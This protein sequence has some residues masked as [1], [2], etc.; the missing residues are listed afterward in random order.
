MSTFRTR[1][2]SFFREQ[3]V[4]T[5]DSKLNG[6]LEVSMSSGRYVLNSESSNYSFGSLHRVFRNALNAEGPKIIELGQVLVLGLGAGSVPHIMHKE[7][8]YDV[9]ITGVE[10][11]KKVLE[12]G[13]KYFGLMK[14]PL[15]EVVHADAHDYVSNCSKLFGLVV[16]DLYVGRDV[17]PECEEEL[18]WAK[19]G[20]IV[21]KP[22]LL[23]FNK[24]VYDEETRAQASR[25]QGLAERYFDSMRVRRIIDTWENHIIIGENQKA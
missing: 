5:Y 1:F 18:F 22:G 13:E 19:L 23:M 6:K 9:K 24:V 20:H 11:D 15:L 7:W 8:K 10:K 12:A 2:L 14:D 3:I 16:V 25:L 17:P 4:E 21:S